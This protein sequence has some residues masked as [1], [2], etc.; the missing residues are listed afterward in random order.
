MRSP[1]E[2]N[3]WLH[4]EYKRDYTNIHAMMHETASI[5]PPNGKLVRVRV[6]YDDHKITAARITGDFFL[7]PTDA[8]ADLEAALVGHS[9]DVDTETLVAAIETVDADLIGFDATDLATA[10]QEALE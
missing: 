6:E 2:R 7:E 8:L 4:S 5:K 3:N 10:T 9:T 1:G